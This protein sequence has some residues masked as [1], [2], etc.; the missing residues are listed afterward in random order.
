MPSSQ[1]AS[2]SLLLHVC[3]HT[4]HESPIRLTHSPSVI[5]IVDSLL[6]RCKFE[7]QSGVANEKRTVFSVLPLLLLSPAAAAAESIIGKT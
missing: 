6:L 3:Q 7:L 4:S 1:G 2:F 5:M